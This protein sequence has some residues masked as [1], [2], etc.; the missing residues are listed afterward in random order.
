VLNVHSQSSEIGAFVGASYYLGDIN[1]GKHYFQPNFS[2]G[3][4]YKYNIDY[5]WA[6]RF[7][8][9]KGKVEGS[10]GVMKFY[11]NRNL[12]FE[13]D[14]NEVALGMELNFLPYIV[15]SRSYK[16]TSYI[17]AEIGYFQ[18]N[19][20][21]QYNGEW[22]DLQPL[23]T[24]GQGTTA[25]PEKKLYKLSEFAFPFGLG[26]KHCFSENFS[27]S[28][29]WGVRKTMTDYIDDISTTYVNSEV[30]SAENSQMS[31]VLADRNLSG[32][33]EINF[34]KQRGDSS[35]N[36]WYSFAGITLFINIKKNKSVCE[37]MTKN[38]IKFFK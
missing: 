19:P 20:R 12:S 5:R 30:L 22:Y 37:G 34:G 31:A 14:I 8:L 1:P 13:S 18:F 15:G 11:E 32:K 16:T 25:Y 7:N 4:V 21:T 6:F 24:E 29:E 2:F 33:S 10:D 26:F 38:R 28:F 3:A 9:T 23:G 35:N 17:F 27:I 36:D